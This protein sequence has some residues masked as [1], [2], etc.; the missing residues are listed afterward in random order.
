MK[1]RIVDSNCNLSF[2]VTSGSGFLAARYLL[3]NNFL[4]VSLNY[5]LG[6]DFLIARVANKYLCRN[7]DMDVK[8]VSRTSVN[9]DCFM[10]TVTDLTNDLSSL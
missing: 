8:R 2:T 1:L 9:E 7:S 3:S 5:K 4:D 6:K 10:K